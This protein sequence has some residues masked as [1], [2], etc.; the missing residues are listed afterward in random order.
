MTRHYADNQRSGFVSS[1]CCLL[2][3]KPHITSLTSLLNP[4]IILH[5]MLHSVSL[6]GGDATI[7]MMN[8]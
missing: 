2:Q 8:I 3:H 6:A 4:V 1:I 7:L 5:C